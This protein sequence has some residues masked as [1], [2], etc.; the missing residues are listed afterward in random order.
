MKSFLKVPRV[1]LPKEPSSEWAVP[2]CDQHTSD[3]PFWERIRKATEGKPST[4]HF[5]LPEVDL[6]GDIAALAEEIREKEYA[7]L[8]RGEVYK[9]DFGCVWVHRTTQSGTRKGIIAC[10]DLE[11]YTYGEGEISPIRSTE[12]VVPKRVAPRVTIRKRALLEFPHALVFYRDKRDSLNKMLAKEQLEE[13]YRIPLM[14]GGGE[15]AGYFLPK[16]LSDYVLDGLES[17]G[18]KA[19]L[20][21]ADGNHSLVAAKTVWE[22]IKPTLSEEERYIHPARFMLVELVNLY[23]EAILFHAIHR[24]ITG[25]DEAFIDRFTKKIKCKRVGNLLYSQLPPS[26]LS[27]IDEAIEECLFADGGEVDYVHMEE[28]EAIGKFAQSDKNGVC[29]YLKSF[30][31]DDLYP[32]AKKGKNLPRKAFSVGE[33][34]EKRYYLEGREISL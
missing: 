32:I 15:V 34:N 19:E 17:G 28:E 5:I 27:K 13:L 8:E 11:A 14:E 9:Q 29:V 10:I 21:V 12:A 7:S 31:K 24:V 18:E 20:L 2:A 1:I 3:P 22:E 16:D 25:S 23:D 30:D 6:K 4:Y 33:G 26:S